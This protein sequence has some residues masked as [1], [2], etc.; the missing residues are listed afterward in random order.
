MSETTRF[1]LL[2]EPTHFVV[3][4]RALEPQDGDRIVRVTEC[5]VCGSD[6][7]MYSGLHPI[8]KPPL[9][10]GHEFYGTV[11][12][13]GGT[14]PAGTEVAIYPPVGC[15]HCYHCSRGLEYLCAEMRFYGG[16]FQGGLSDRVAVRE[17]NL[18]PIPDGVP[19]EQRVLI[20]P[21]SVAVHAAA[22][23]AVSPGEAA[24]V[25]GAGPIGL[26]TALVLQKQGAV[27]SLA[28][29][30]LSVERLEKA[31]RFGLE[32]VD[33][34]ERQ[35]ID[36]VHEDVR[37]EGVDVVLECIGSVPTIQQAL[38]LTCK[39]GRVIHVGNGSPELTLDG[40]FLQRGER[41]LVGVLM[42]AREDFL[43]AMELLASGLLD[44]LPPE[45]LVQR[46]TLDR[47]SD[48]FHGLKDG[49]I[50]ALKASIAVGAQ[51]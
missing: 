30:D 50:H 10:L 2:D 35:L 29:A 36:Y 21:L 34:N 26:L 23:A 38:S 1:A 28:I 9:I 44:G 17:Q 16:E 8:F 49:S 24:L 27:G 43:T 39:G 15:G 12:G 32:T 19:R 5:G 11:E 25:M 40:V 41:S 42:Y 13:D 3:D 14:I 48:V 20:E 4:E 18:L 51:P 37:P 22:R 7:K 33:V 45:D 46:F 47:V 31:Q 6:L